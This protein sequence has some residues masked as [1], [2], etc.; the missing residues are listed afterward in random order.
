M[1]NV[2]WVG[3]NTTPAHFWLTNKNKQLIITGTNQ[4]HSTYVWNK[5]LDKYGIPTTTQ[6]E[7]N[8]KQSIIQ[9][10][11]EQYFKDKGV[12]EEE[13]NVLYNKQDARDYAINKWNWIRF[14]YD[15]IQLRELSYQ[16][17][18]RIPSGNYNIEIM[19][20]NRI[21]WGYRID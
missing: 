13:I 10:Q 15:N 18:K 17:K 2:N 9:E 20:S 1:Y 21:L 7:Y 6:V 14:F 12:M 8:N 5:I 19:K 16:N 4:T 3:V 11:D